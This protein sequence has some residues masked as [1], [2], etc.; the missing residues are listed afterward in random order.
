[1][2]VLGSV[3]LPGVARSVATARRFVGEMLSRGLHIVGE[4][5]DECGIEVEAGATTIWVRLDFA[6][7]AS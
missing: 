3:T 2:T 4:L 6:D 1:M 7:S 5:A